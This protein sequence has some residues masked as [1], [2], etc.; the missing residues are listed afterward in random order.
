MHLKAEVQG[1]KLAM[2]SLSLGLP[3]G[4]EAPVMMPDGVIFLFLFLHLLPEVTSC[5]L[6]FLALRVFWPPLRAPFRPP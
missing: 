5:L 4:L 1:A 3:L 6:L 2:H